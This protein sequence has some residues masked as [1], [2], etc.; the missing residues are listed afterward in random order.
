M[1]LCIPLAKGLGEMI[2]FSSAVD[3]GS[4]MWGQSVTAS[5]C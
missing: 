1:K 4:F 2:P 3:I 5:L